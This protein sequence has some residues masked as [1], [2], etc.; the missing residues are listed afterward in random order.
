M[1]KLIFILFASF[2]IAKA[3]V[4]TVSPA[5]PSITDTITITFNASQGNGALNNFN[6]DV[7]ILLN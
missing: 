3:Q 7:Y 6:G 4:V 2:S 5:Y 1:K